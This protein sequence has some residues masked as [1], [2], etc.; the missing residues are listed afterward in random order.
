MAACLITISGTSG[1]LQLNY[2]IGGISKS[3]IESGVGSFYIEDTA[4][5]V[6]YTTLFGDVI[7]SSACLTIVAEPFVCYNIR[8]KG[9]NAE[10]YKFIN[11]ALGETIYT[12]TEA[13]FPNAESTLP[14]SVNEL[15]VDALKITSYKRVGGSGFSTTIPDESSVEHNFIVRVIGSE[16][17]IFKIRNA[18]TTAYIYVYGVVSTCA[19]IGYTDVILC[20]P[21]PLS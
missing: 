13:N 3:P 15:G 21:A 17:P 5:E 20:N 12:L 6:T 1:Q 4:T 16:I 8:W 10:G 19:P 7:A 11:V 18:D 9:I 2:K 14:N